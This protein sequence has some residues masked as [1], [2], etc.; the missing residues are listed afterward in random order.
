[1]ITIFSAVFS[2]SC[3]VIDVRFFL[4]ATDVPRNFSVIDFFFAALDARAAGLAFEAGE[5]TVRQAL[6]RES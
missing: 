1:M 3:F 6:R 4:A 5:E 2:R